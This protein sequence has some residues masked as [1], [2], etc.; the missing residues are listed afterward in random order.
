G[1]SDRDLVGR[2]GR[3]VGLV[4]F[5][6]L[7]EN[8]GANNDPVLPRADCRQVDVD[9]AG[10]TVAGLEGA[11]SR[12]VAQEDVVDVPGGIRRKVDAVAPQAAGGKDAD[13]F[14]RP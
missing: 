13:V 10:V 4:A 9:R 12:D 2:G 6:D 3:V 8:V 7:V 1:N 11:A 14:G 5:V